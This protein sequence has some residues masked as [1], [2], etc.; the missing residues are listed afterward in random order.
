MIN[1]TSVIL[2]HMYLKGGLDPFVTVRQYELMLYL[3]KKIA[4]EK[5]IKS[6]LLTRLDFFF[7]DVKDFTLYNTNLD[8]T[9]TVFGVDNKHI[10]SI[11]RQDFSEAVE[12][13][14]VNDSNFLVV[15]DHLVNLIEGFETD[16][17]LE[18]LAVTEYLVNTKNSRKMYDKVV[19]QGKR[20]SERQFSVA[21]TR[22][23]DYSKVRV[24]S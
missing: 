7:D 11:S 20:F 15:V 3:A 21:K 9:Q 16:F 13:I 19:I 2:S 5:G 18:L 24:A 14:N 23:Q 10:E 12:Y 8:A 1:E 6:S 4:K 22:L 17:G